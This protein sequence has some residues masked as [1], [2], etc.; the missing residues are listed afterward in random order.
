VLAG[1]ERYGYS[2][3]KQSKQAIDEIVTTVCPE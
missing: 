3:E 1:V 2:H